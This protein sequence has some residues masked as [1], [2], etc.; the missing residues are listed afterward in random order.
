MKLSTSDIARF[1]H[2]TTPRKIPPAIAKAAINGYR[3]YLAY[4]T[5]IF[6]VMYAVILFPCRIQL[7]PAKLAYDAIVLISCIV[8]I[9]T[10]IWFYSR[11]NRH[12]L[13]L[14]RKGRFAYG[15]SVEE[16]PSSPVVNKMAAAYVVVVFID[17]YGRRRFANCDVFGAVDKKRCM[18]WNS[19]QTVT[20]TN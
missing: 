1:V 14:L 19:D 20:F 9:G 2:Q 7:L 4:I 11:N 18:M 6:F 10:I 12:L 5:A 13:P 8:I 16:R 3:L 17:K 15:N